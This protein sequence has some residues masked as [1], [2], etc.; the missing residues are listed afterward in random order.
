MQTLSAPH[1]LAAQRLDYDLLLR[2]PSRLNPVGDRELLLRGLRLQ[3]IENLAL[4]KDQ[5]DTLDLTDN[6]IRRLD[7]FPLMRRLKALLLANNRIARIDPDLHNWPDLADLDPLMGLEHLE[8][9][10][11]IDNPVALKKHYRAY[12]LHRC[13]SVRILDFRRVREQERLEAAALFSGEKG[14]AL[15]NSLSARPFEPGQDIIV[16]T[17]KLPPK[18]APS[19]HV[20]AHA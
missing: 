12:V 7:S 11:L 2:A 17:D 3:R 5:N 18:K 9:L 8:T 16:D 13:P 19:R 14:M 15:V 10:S 1:G 6:D 20:R 4:T